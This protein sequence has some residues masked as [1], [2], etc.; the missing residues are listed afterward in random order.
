[1][2]CSSVSGD[3]QIPL[4]KDRQL[5]SARLAELDSKVACR[6][7]GTTHQADSFDEDKQLL[8]LGP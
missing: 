5:D 3:T 1:M 7:R 8:H 4:A 6:I 2:K